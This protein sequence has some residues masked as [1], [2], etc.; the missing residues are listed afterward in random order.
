MTN[1]AQV[2]DTIRFPWEEQTEEFTVAF[3]QPEDNAWYTQSAAPFTRESC[4]AKIES[5][6]AERAAKVARFE[7]EAADPRLHV[8]SRDLSTRLAEHYRTVEYRIVS[9]PVEAWTIVA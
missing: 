8:E 7:A 6:N 1:S 5:L 9:R 4:E 3:Y 2:G